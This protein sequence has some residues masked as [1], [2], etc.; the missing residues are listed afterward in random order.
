MWFERE[1]QEFGVLG[2][3][4]LGAQ[5]H[6]QTGTP[7]ITPRRRLGDGL[8]F[9]SSPPL[10]SRLNASYSLLRPSTHSRCQ[11]IYSFYRYLPSMRESSKLDKLAFVGPG[12]DS[13]RNAMQSFSRYGLPLLNCFKLIAKT[14]SA[15]EKAKCGER[16]FLTRGYHMFQTGSKTNKTGQE[17]R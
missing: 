9:P 4:L 13:P 16:Y 3:L 6:T 12:V 11:R 17:I 15:P 5:L 14:F 2:S 1:C 8:E 7:K 10:E